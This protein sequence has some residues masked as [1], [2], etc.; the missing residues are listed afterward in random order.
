MLS[1]KVA[2]LADGFPRLPIQAYLPSGILH[3]AAN[4]ST[5]SFHEPVE[6]RLAANAPNYCWARHR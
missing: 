4:L 6:P 5:C 3:L 1:C 2:G